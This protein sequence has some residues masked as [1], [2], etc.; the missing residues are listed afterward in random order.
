M[1]RWRLHDVPR[2]CFEGQR[3]RKSFDYVWR[4]ELAWRVQRE[5]ALARTEVRHTAHP[6]PHFW[7][8]N[9][10]GLARTITAPKLCS[11]NSRSEPKEHPAKACPVSI[12]RPSG[13]HYF[14]EPL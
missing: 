5:Q 14:H 3:H 1:R 7:F 10:I 2:Q 6:V 4:L 11:Y 13:T 12:Y 8:W 9:T